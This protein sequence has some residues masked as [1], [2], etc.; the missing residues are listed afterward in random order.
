MFFENLAEEAKVDP[1][2]PVVIKNA[3]HA[4]K[5]IARRSK[6]KKYFERRKSSSKYHKYLIFC[7]FDKKKDYFAVNFACTKTLNS[8][9]LT[10]QW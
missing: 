2:K 1:D 10:F 7:L 8:D 4:R 3:I 9:T 6:A 5:T